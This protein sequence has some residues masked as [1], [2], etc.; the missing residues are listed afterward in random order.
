MG[1]NP[2][3]FATGRQGGGLRAKR[4]G[5]DLESVVLASCF[6]GRGRVCRLTKIGTGTRWIKDETGQ[7]KTVPQKSFVDFTGTVCG[8]GRHIC[9]DAKSVGPKDASFNAANEAVLKPKQIQLL[10]DH[11]QANAIA[12]V[13]VRCDRLQL[14]LW[15]RHDRLRHRSRL[16]WES[17]DWL[18]LG[19]ST[20][21]VPLRLLIEAYDR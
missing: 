1:L 16:S 5:D 8:T 17:S 10:E 6:D 18:E 13:L 11:G 3:I 14:F 15:L 7:L 19:P 4:A 21:P 2:N 20:R 12:G 9:F